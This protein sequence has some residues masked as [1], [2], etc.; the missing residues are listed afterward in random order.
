MAPSVSAAYLMTQLVPLKTAPLRQIR[1]FIA[2][3]NFPARLSPTS[4]A[5]G[6]CTVQETS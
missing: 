3:I 6:R 2:F 1:H 4:A 5:F